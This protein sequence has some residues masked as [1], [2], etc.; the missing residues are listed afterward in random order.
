MCRNVCH[1]IFP[2]PALHGGGLD[3]V[4]EHYPVPTRF[5]AI[6]GEDVIF[7]GNVSR[8]AAVL[9]KGLGKLGVN[10]HRLLRRLSFG[11]V[12]LATDH[13]PL[14]DMARFSQSISPH[15]SPESH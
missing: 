4:S 15:R 9:Q 10:G 8:L 6:P 14:N 1:P 3:M 12:N 13:A 5:A 2:I 11:L 7:R